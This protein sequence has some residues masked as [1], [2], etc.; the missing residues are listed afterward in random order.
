M[1]YESLQAL[2][3]DS[4]TRDSDRQAEPAPHCR[5]Q[6]G[7]PEHQHAVGEH[8][9]EL[10]GPFQQRLVLFIGLGHEGQEQDGRDQ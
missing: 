8:V 4:Q 2:D 7:K 3:R 6:V 10:V 5:L 9:L 1:A